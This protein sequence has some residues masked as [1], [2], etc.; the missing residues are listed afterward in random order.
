MARILQW[1][2][3]DWGKNIFIEIQCRLS[4]AS[5]R[6]PG[7]AQGVGTDP[8]TIGGGSLGYHSRLAS[9]PHLIS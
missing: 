1:P 7:R 3:A 4:T 6:A 5:D 2:E 8:V 9:P